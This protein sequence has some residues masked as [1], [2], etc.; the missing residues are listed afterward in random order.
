VTDGGRTMDDAKRRKLGERFVAATSAVRSDAVLLGRRCKWGVFT[1]NALADYVPDV[2]DGG[3]MRAALEWAREM[4][5]RQWLSVCGAAIGPGWVVVDECGVVEGC[6][7]LHD[8]EAEAHVALA[9]WAA[10]YRR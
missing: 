1:N 4:T 6:D 10:E 8:T 7:H 9:E 3:T 5:G 2:L